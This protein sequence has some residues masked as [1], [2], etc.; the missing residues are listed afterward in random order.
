MPNRGVEQ[1]E[2]QEVWENKTIWAYWDG[3]NPPELVKQCVA[4]WRK[5]TA[6]EGWTVVLLNKR[7]P[8]LP[9]FSMV[10]GHAVYSDQV[11]LYLLITYGGLWLDASIFLLQ[12]LTWLTDHIR[13]HRITQFTGFQM[14]FNTMENWLIAAPRKGSPALIEWRDTFHS[15]LDAFPDVHKH[16]AYAVQPCGQVGLNPRYFMMYQAFCYLRAKSPTFARAVKEAHLM[17][18]PVALEIIPFTWPY[19]NRRFIKYVNFTRNHWRVLR[20]IPQMAS[21]AAVLVILAIATWIAFGPA[22]PFPPPARE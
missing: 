4:S 21:L 11:R 19:D 10:A 13:R 1:M 8:L 16:P 3:P 14:I 6:A 12:P 5:Q 18:S 20:F 7:S 15:I 17:Q 9:E 22:R 2:T